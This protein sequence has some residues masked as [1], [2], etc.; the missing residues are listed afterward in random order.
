MSEKIAKNEIDNKLMDA[1][2]WQLWFKDHKAE[3][4]LMITVDAKFA[5]AEKCT[6]LVD[7]YN[8]ITYQNLTEI[9]ELYNDQPITYYRAVSDDY[10]IS[11]TR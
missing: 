5:E 9:A 4:N 11:I 2:D 8:N 10:Q 6:H 1:V 3:A 7:V